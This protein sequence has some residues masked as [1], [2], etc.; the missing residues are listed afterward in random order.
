M[1]LPF[2][3]GSRNTGPAPPYLPEMHLPLAEC[4]REQTKAVPKLPQHDVGQTE[5]DYAEVEAMSIN[6]YLAIIAAFLFGVG[7]GVFIVGSFD[8]SAYRKGYQ[9]GLQ[10][11]GS[12]IADVAEGVLHDNT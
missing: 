9:D 5:E 11:A 12:V 10:T 7:L 2:S 3:T 4:R 6:M 1:F 8:I